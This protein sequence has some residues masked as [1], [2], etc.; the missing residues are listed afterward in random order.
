MN[1]HRGDI[2]LVDFPYSNLM[3]SK[4]R[5]A[6]VVQSEVWNQ[7]LDDTILALITSSQRRRIGASTQYVIEISTE[8]GKQTGL[9]LDSIVQCENLITYEQSNILKILGS[10]PVSEM[11]MV[12]KCLKAAL[13]IT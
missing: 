13:G 5:P 10:L 11:Q 3:G 2:V 6:L 9:R 8:T 1:I 12:D 7:K 4:L